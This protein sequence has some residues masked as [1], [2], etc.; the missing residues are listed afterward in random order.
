MQR[1]DD[2]RGHCSHPSES[3]DAVGA[4]RTGWIGDAGSTLVSVTD[5]E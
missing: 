1:K 2:L 3:E 4:E 5:G